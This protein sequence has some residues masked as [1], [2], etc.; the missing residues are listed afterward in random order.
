MGRAWWQAGRL[1]RK[2]T[3]FTDHIAAA[4]HLLAGRVS[5]HRHS[6]ACRPED[7]LQA[8]VYGMRPDLWAAVVAEVP[9]VDVVT[10]M[11]DDTIPL[12]VNEWDEWGD[13]RRA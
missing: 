8:A 11:L 2:V 7:L 4:E 9:F 6:R 5:K 13:P 10:T 1:D 3:T 12:T